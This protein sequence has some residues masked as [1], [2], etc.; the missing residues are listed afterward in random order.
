M[1]G[2]I[3][4]PDKQRSPPKFVVFGVLSSKGKTCCYFFSP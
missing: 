2:K 4:G 1:S 3:K